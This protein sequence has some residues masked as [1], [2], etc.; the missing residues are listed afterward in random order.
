MDFAR[1]L[2]RAAKPKTATGRILS[3]V[4]RVRA[5]LRGGEDGQALVEAAI[6]ITVFMMIMMCIITLSIIYKN[7][8]ILTQAVGSSAQYLQSLT[9]APAGTDPC[10]L[11]YSYLQ[12]AAPTLSQTITVHFTLGS[13]PVITNNSCSLSEIQPSSSAGSENI[14]VEAWYPC[15]FVVLTFSGT[16]CQIYA[17][18]SEVIAANE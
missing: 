5:C 8:I 6:S 16:G 15:T 10:A 18:A 1:G 11:T 3:P 4:E 9:T 12:G 14:K 7:Q 13:N 17:T 2:N